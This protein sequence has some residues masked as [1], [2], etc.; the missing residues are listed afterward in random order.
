MNKTVTINISG[1]IF[2][3]DEGAFDKLQGYLHSIK[4]KF[5]NT[6]GGE[7][8]LI[9]IEARIAEIFHEKVTDRKQV[10]ALF[11]VEE[12]I[13]IMGQ[14]EQF[15]DGNAEANASNNAKE[16]Q[17]YYEPERKGPKRFFR[18]PDSKILGG[19]S[20]GIAHYFGVDPVII[21]LLFVAVVFFGGSGVIIYLI[22]WAITPEAKTTSE[23]LQMKGQKVDIDSIRQSVG[24]EADHLKKKFSHLGK[25]ADQF[26]RKMDAG[27]VQGF[28]GTFLN[29]IFSIVKLILTFIG[30]FFGII[31]I[32]FGGLFLLSLVASLFGLAN[33]NGLSHIAWNYNSFSIKEVYDFLFLT[34]YQRIAITIGIGLAA[35]IPILSMLYAGLKILFNIQSPSK[36]IG[37]GV[38]LAWF[39]GIV[40]LLVTGLQIGNEFSKEDKVVSE[41]SLPPS[42]AD[43]IYITAD[44]SHYPVDAVPYEDNEDFFILKSYEDELYMTS[45]ELDVR[46]NNSDSI[47]ISVIQ[48]ARGK[49][50][51]EAIERA[52]NIEYSY[53]ITDNSIKFNPYFILRRADLYRKQSVKIR[54][55]I[56]VGKTVY[57][58]KTSGWLIYDITNTTSTRDKFMLGKYWTMTERGLECQHMDM[59]KEGIRSRKKERR[60]QPS[61]KPVTPTLKNTPKTT[62]QQADTT[63]TAVITPAEEH[64]MQPLFPTPFTIIT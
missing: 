16:E 25:K 19:V 53:S 31:L 3:I 1:I 21:R 5:G 47:S 63:T 17:S 34:N 9:D 54:V 45:V 55:S 18:D 15:E 44:D 60:V 20:S 61:S 36:G 35:G 56:P 4:Q 46:E 24:E 59:S 39:A 38:T 32:I 8:I 41:F 13:A 2:N 50:Y 42:V 27:K 23:K 40:L 30:K 57:L 28:L 22:L 14:P 37:A 12:V 52:E 62:K 64:E 43:T 7:E 49:T 48:E 6:Q 51:E 11:D 26:G 58:D 10:I 29:F 33:V